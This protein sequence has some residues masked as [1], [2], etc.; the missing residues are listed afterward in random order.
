MAVM[1][2]LMAGY[3]PEESSTNPNAKDNTEEKTSD[4]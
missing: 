2:K 1:Q 4:K 3:Q